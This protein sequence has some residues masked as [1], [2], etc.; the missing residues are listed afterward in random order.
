[1]IKNSGILILEKLGNIFQL[2]GIASMMLMAFLFQIVLH[3]LPCPLC[4][5]QRIG[6]LGIA[7][8][9]LL[10]LRFGFRPSHYAIVLFS[11]LFTSFVALRQI[12]LH[13]IPGSAAYG[14]PVFGFHLYT[15]SFIIAMIFVIS[16]TFL[17]AF[18]RQ[19]QM[20]SVSIKK[21]D[22]ISHSLF[23]I[24][25]LLVLANIVSVLLECGIGQCPD[26]PTQYF[27]WA[28]LKSIL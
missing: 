14:D 23:A 1:M 11:A 16:T 8:G 6:F 26:N 25:L 5:L 10:N 4:L 21:L 20:N 17:L 7:F 3:E 13:V 15:W 28:P 9:L 22:W 18:D 27:I 2:L 19:Y 24:L 12:G